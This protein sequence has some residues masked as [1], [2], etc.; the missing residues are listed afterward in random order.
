MDSSVEVTLVC[1]SKRQADGAL[2]ALKAEVDRLESVLSDYRPESNVSRLNRRQT[3]VPAPEA[4]LLLQR[5][6]DV[7]HQ[8][9]GAFDVSVG[10]I[11][12]LWGFG[13]GGSPHVPHPDSIRTLLLHV[14]C[15]VYALAPDGRL[16]WRD[17]AARID[18]GGIAQGY[19]ASCMADTLRARGISSFLIDVSGDIV[20]DGRRPDGGPW[21]IGIQHPRRSD[22]LLARLPL[23]TAAVTT[24]GDYEQYFMTG[25]VRY[26]HLFDPATGYPARGAASATVFSDDPVAA[27]CFATALFVLGPERGLQF[28]ADRTDLAALF[29]L[30]R[31]DGGVQ[32]RASSA[33]AAALALNPSTE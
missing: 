5:A 33:L 3:D 18:L 15:D 8:T 20:A 28:L 21:R 31:P 11:K 24:S 23:T 12:R 16:Q 4:R 26:H 30:E 25:G 19:V 10:P 7:C 29:V 2:Q 22:S 13:T 14:G 27:D 1:A 17:A 6:H 9:G 32:M